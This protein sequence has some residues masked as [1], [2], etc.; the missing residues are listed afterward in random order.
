M[1]YNSYPEP[2]QAF[3]L[4]FSKYNRGRDIRLCFFV[5]LFCFW[6]MAEG[7]GADE[8]CNASARGQLEEVVGLLRNGA[9]INGF[10]KFNRTPLQVSIKAFSTVN[11]WIFLHVPLFC[12]LEG[13]L[14]TSYF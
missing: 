7:F 2:R 5:F 3:L 10:N 6:I 12:L 14:V 1:V 8:L 11:K 4:N 9:D 13:N